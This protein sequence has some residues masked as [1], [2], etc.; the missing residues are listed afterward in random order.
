[1]FLVRS[2]GRAGAMAKKCSGGC[3][4]LSVFEQQRVVVWIPILDGRG[5]SWNV[6]HIIDRSPLP[7]FGKQA[8][9]EAKQ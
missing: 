1:M 4:L 9:N 5:L 6:V 7:S 2:W 3:A 8:M